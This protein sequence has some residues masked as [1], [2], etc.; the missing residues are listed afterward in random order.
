MANWAFEIDIA[1]NYIVGL[2]ETLVDK[3]FRIWCIHHDGSPVY[4]FSSEYLSSTPETEVY[5]TARQ[6]VRFIDGVTYLLFE[7]KDN[8]NKIALTTV[9][10]A[11]TLRTA[12]LQQPDRMP[13]TLRIN[14]SVYTPMVQEDDAPA[15]CLLKLVQSDKFLRGLLLVLSQ[16]MDFKSMYQAYDQIT[17]FLAGKAADV[18]SLGFSAAKLSRFTRETTEHPMA[19]K[20]AQELISDIVFA[21]LEKYYRINLKHHMIKDSTADWNDAYDSLY[22]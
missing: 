4:L 18:A 8:V 19:I 3:G 17:A 6:L 11:D 20:E 9:I 22:D 10:D 16:G 21:V 12:H 7:N 13:A 1:D 14:F 15:A 5:I 2:T